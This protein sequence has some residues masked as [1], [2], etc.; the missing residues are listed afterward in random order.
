MVMKR[1]QMNNEKQKWKEFIIWIVNKYNLQ[2]QN[3]KNAKITY[4]YYMPTKRRFDLDNMTPK[5][6]NDGLV[7][8]GLL[9]DDSVF[10]INP[11]VLNGGYDKSNPRV[12][13]LIETG[14]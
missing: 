10:C 14:E 6:I 12:E 4:T 5:F 11:I 1:P 8:S 9:T 7:E 13:M 2:N 3:I